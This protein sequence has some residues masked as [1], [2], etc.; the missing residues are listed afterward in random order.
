[1]QSRFE[2]LRVY[3]QSTE[4]SSKTKRDGTELVYKC[5][6]CQKIGKNLKQMRAHVREICGDIL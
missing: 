2:P 5:P 6:N 3:I 1:M 4:G